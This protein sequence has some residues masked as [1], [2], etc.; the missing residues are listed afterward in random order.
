MADHA[1][2]GIFLKQAMAGKG[3]ARMKIVGARQTPNADVGGAGHAHDTFQWIPAL[4]SRT[5]RGD[6]TGA[7]HRRG[8]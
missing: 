2:L 1:P 5:D 4:E 6:T 8:K 7:L 3:V